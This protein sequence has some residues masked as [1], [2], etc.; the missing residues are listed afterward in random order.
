[1]NK[2]F[3]NKSAHIHFIGIGGSGMYPLAQ[4]LHKLGYSLTGS[5]NNETE[6]LQAVR[7][8]GIPVQLGQRAENIGDAEVI[9]HTAAIMEDNPELMA[10]RASGAR[11]L[12]RSELLGLITESFGNAVCVSGTHGKTTVTSMIAQILVMKGMDI[13]AVIGG[14]LPLIHG[15]GLAGES[16]VMVCEACEFQDHFLHL[17]PDTAVILNIDEDHLDYFKNLDNIIRSFHKFCEKTSRTIIINGG[18]EN[19]MRAVEGITGKEIVTFGADDHCDWYPADIKHI[20]GLHTEFSIMH[21]G[22]LFCRTSIH[23]PGEHNIVNA[24]AAAAAAYTAGAAAEDVKRGLESF[25]GAG[26]RFEKYG[27]IGG[28]TVVDDYAHHPAEITVTLNAAVKLGF[29]RVWAVHQ[30]FTF[31]RTALLLEDFAKALSI[32]DKVALTAIMGGREKNTQ[33]IHTA[34]LAEKIPDC[35]YFEEEEHDANFELTAQYVTEHAEA[36]DLI[37]TLGCGDVNKVSRRI[38]KLLE[39]KYN[40]N[41]F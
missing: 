25:G 4:I 23:V 26:R 31:S 15:S 11:V 33:N 30:P 36:G 22:E 27:E 28:I 24:V 34:A 3:F 20:S 19:S 17:A 29:K 1:M 37:V 21:S 16:E 39:E 38:L 8:M 6:T 7:D 13:S 18:D 35:V 9:V 5:D 12:E 10:A 14:K 32:A 2:H 40:E 41:K